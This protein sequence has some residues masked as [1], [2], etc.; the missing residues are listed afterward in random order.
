[1]RGNGERHAGWVTRLC[2]IPG[3]AGSQARVE[4]QRVQR[5]KHTPRKAWHRPTSRYTVKTLED[6]CFQHSQVFR[7][8]LGK[9]VD[10]VPFDPA[11][12]I[13]R[14][15]SVSVLTPNGPIH[16]GLKGRCRESP[17]CEQVSRGMP[18]NTEHS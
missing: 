13:P 1:M 16:N 4:S 8:H 12:V 3:W 9:L 2:K 15:P 5:G 11:V 6:N 14:R 10:I 17:A 18:L 7:K